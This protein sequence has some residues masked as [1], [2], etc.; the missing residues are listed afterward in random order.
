MNNETKLILEAD[1]KRA[2]LNHFWLIVNGETVAYLKACYEETGETPVLNLFDIETREGY[3]GWVTPRRLCPELVRCSTLTKSPTQ[4]GIQYSD[5][6][7]YSRMS[8]T[9]ARRNI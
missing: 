2:G 5:T 7:G 6:S 8:T 9:R 1:H 3:R 4:A